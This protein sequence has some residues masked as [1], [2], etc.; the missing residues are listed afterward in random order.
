[1]NAKARL[2][3]ALALPALVAASD[4]A[5]PALHLDPA[6]YLSAPGLDVIVFDDIYPDGH[7]TGVTVIQQGV[8]VAANGDVRLSPAPGQWSPMPA[9]GKRTVDKQTGT[10]TQTMHFPDPAKNGH[11]FNPIFYPDLDLGY[12]V[13]VTPLA[14][15]SFRI[16][17]DLDKPL[18][19]EW[20]GKAGFNLELFPGLLFGKSWLMD[21]QSGVF[22]PQPEGPIRLQDG[23]TVPVPRNVTGDGPTP[24]PNGEPLPVP[25]AT[26]HK[27]VVAPETDAQRMTITSDGAPL[28]LL[29]GRLPHN[30]GWFV[31][32]SAI[33]AGATKN[34]ITWTVTPNTVPDWRYTPVIQVS[35]IGYAPAQ[36]KRAVIELDGR[37]T[38]AQLKPVTLFRLTD[39]GREQVMAGKGEPWGKF[40]RYRYVTL[41]F[42]RIRDPGMYQI[43]YGDQLS[44]PFRIDGNVYARGAWQPTLEYFLPVQMC[45][46]RVNEKYRVW[47]GLDHQD[48]ALMA[49]TGL[50]HIDGY[51][52]GPS[53]LTR[54]KPGDVVPGLDRGGWHDAGDYDLRVESQIGTTWM[55]A[56]M[57]EEFGLNYDAT[58]IDEKNRIVEIHDPDGTNDAIQQIE[59]GLLTVLG[60]YRALGRLYRGII[61]PSLR[62]YVMLGDAANHTDNVSK[63]PVKGLGLDTNGDP[64]KWDDRWVFTEDN[65]DR[66]LYVAGGLAGAARV[67]KAA[68]RPMADEALAAAKN[69]A[70]RALGREKDNSKAVFA[71]A[72]LIHTTHDPAYVARLAALEPYILAH[73]DSTGWMLAEI[74]DQ[75]PGKFRADLAQAVADYQAKVAA[76]AKTDSP[77]GIPYK[78][79][80]WGAGWDI[81]QRGVEQYFFHKGWPRATS[82][83]SYMNALD[84]VLGVHPGENT[85]SFVSGVGSASATVAYGANRADWSYIPGGVISGTNLIRPDLPELKTW[86]YFWQQTEYVMG[87]GATNY[88]F[89]ALAADRLYGGKR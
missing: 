49:P 4:A 21:K 62:R 41:D 31:I 60:G 73:I 16:S 1:M 20:V 87:G 79:K 38:D 32:R 54:Y 68:G 30:N 33:P 24:D 44:H 18:P 85:A 9:S 84:F 65:P 2:L 50:N 58:T 43:G 86:P 59:H 63:K 47:H 46:M 19:P 17:V 11:G 48:D 80:I 15:G 69:I 12:A 26:G 3:A 36:P 71:L 78:P 14:G 67:L 51:A 34:A 66:E 45:H 70:A 81:Q 22:A 35:Q 57:V 42:S 29:D 64:I 37:T 40:L 7:Q 6:G 89:L 23:G 13:R 61:T 56:K 88:M 27:L 83:D 82:T 76:D 75:L 77:Y 10:I 53:T 52:Q 55:L 5:A 72:E 28:E 74:Q 25:M 39:H 8:R